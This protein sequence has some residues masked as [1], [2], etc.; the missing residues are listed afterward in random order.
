[1]VTKDQRRRQLA[2]EKFERQQQRRVGQ[3]AQDPQTQRGDR[4]GGGRR[5]W[6]RAAPR[7]RTGAFDGDDGK[8]DATQPAEPG[9][10]ALGVAAAPPAADPCAKPAAGTPGTAQ[11][12]TEP[13]MA[14]D[15]SAH[16]HLHA[17]DHLRHHP[18]RAG[19]GEG[20]GTR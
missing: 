14:I 13:A 18:D 3:H 16:V 11:W 5:A 7:G 1:M 17:A 12:K 9:R 15:K 10:R 19:R 8:D 20:A 6:P 4:R 2:R